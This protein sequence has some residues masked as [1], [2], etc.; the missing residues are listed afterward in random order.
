M[1][2]QQQEGQNASVFSRLRNVL[3]SPIL[4][5]VLAMLFWGA[6]TIVVR[7]VREDAPPMGLAFWRNITAFVVLLPFA[8][9]PLQQQWPL[10]RENLG[11]LAVLALLLWV[12]GNTLLILALQYTIAIN[13]AVINSIEPV[14]IILFAWLL[15]RDRFTWLQALGVIISLIGVLYLI[16]DGSLERLTRLELNIGDLIVTCAY[17]FWALYA[18]LLRKAP[19]G[20]DARVMVLVLIGM[21]AFFILPLY[22]LEVMFFRTFRV[23]VTTVT[24]V[25]FLAVFASIFATLMW[26]RSIKLMGASQAALYLHLIPV[27]TVILAILFLGEEMALFHVVGI[28]LV[29]TGIYITSRQGGH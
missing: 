13:A 27:F 29:A 3:M 8:I 22:I 4:A 1:E 10:V 23:T 26:N 14:F 2:I 18:V 25:L 17:A 11:I 21:G 28:A 19:R 15:F 5:V 7:Y 12:G 6:T 24:T 20:L 9:R 16:S